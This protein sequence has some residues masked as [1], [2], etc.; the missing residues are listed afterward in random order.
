MEQN[1]IF[2]QDKLST[3]LNTI[4]GVLNFVQEVIRDVRDGTEVEAHE[5][6]NSDRQIDTARRILRELREHLNLSHIAD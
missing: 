6:I 2:E 4:E 3:N 1:A 5:L